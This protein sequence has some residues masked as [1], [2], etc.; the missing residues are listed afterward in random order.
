MFAKIQKWN[1]L[2]NQI[3]V[4]FLV[5]MAIVLLI[6]SFL[7]FNQ[8]SSL[9]KKNA[10]K[11]IQQTAVE[12]NGR[13]D[14]L[15]EQVNTTSKLVMT[16]DSIQGAMAKEYGGKHVTYADSQQLNRIVNTIQA[17]SNGIFSF[18][19][20]AKN[21]KRILPYDDTSLNSRIDEK[22]IQ[23]A[24]KARGRLVWTG[25]DSRDPH[26]IV[27]LRRVNLVNHDYAYAGYLLVRI[28]CD[29]FQSADQSNN[30]NQY[31]ILLDRQLHPIF[32][33]YHGS[34]EPIIKNRAL[35]SVSLNKQDY[36][37]TK[38]T[39]EDTGWTFLILTPVKEL[40]KGVSVIRAGI[41][42]SGIIGLFIFFICS[43]FLSNIITNPIIKLTKTMEQASQGSLSLN[44][45][46]T[47][48]SEINKLNS[49]YNQ[50]AKET[51]HLIKMVY[52]KELTRSRSELKALQAQ[53]NPHFLFNTLD[54]LRWSLEENDEE[55]LAELVIAMSNLFRYTI[56]KQ[57]GGDWVTIKEEMDH[58]ENYMEIMKMR[59][60]N[61]LRWDITLPPEWGHIKIPKLI[62]QPL[63]ENA[64]LHGAGN[65]L[66]PCT[67]TVWIHPS[68]EKDYLKVLV[69]DDGPGINP[70]KLVFIRNSMKEGGLSSGKGGNGMAL[71]NVHKRLELYYQGLLKKGL[72]ITSRENVGTTV[73]FEIPIMGEEEHCLTKKPS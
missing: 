8:V 1:T 13:L 49:T 57:K 5:V 11:Q 35:P 18:E 50:L 55:E 26:F 67:I 70:E 27:A 43:L 73:S 4:N 48:V 53:I 61:Q 9:V 20:Y 68:A 44:P 19:L 23:Q 65:K 30:T 45:S 31:S 6:V 63:V 7:M 72:T 32:S 37:I 69:S 10:N 62:I 46:V 66:Q 58:I 17:N 24:N 16:N 51:N 3:L 12:A 39:S 38:Q 36:M 15:Y 2:R 60:G 59:F 64:V 33:N 25:V 14:S 54:A 40:T 21:Q 29:Y 41:I 22:W 56:T 34:L 52:Q 47:T 71:S 42:F 28:Y